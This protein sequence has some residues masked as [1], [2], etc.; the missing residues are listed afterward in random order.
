MTKTQGYL[1]FV[2]QAAKPKTRVWLVVG[3]SGAI[4]TVHWGAQWRK[5]VFSAG[6]N[7]Y[8]DTACLAEIAEFL[9]DKT[10]EHKH[11]VLKE[12]T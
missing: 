6:P 9:S 11:P 10:F 3:G 2:E 5:Y 1:R 7:T 4:G 8:Y 12:A